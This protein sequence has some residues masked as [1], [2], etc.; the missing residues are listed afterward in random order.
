MTSRI[1]CHSAKLSCDIPRA[2]DMF[3]LNEH[4]Q[5]WL[6]EIADVEPRLGGKYELFWDPEDK[7][8][9]STIGCKVTAIEKH[10]FLAFEWKGPKQFNHFMNVASPLTHVVVFFLPC[11][12]SVAE[13]CTEVHLI[14]TGWGESAEWEEARLWFEKA[15]N[16][17]FDR[18]RECVGHQ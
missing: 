1:L 5:I 17:A 18:L 10:R 14:H 7:D 8:N 15:W 16:L 9:N 4:L 6:A 3:T 13:P 11:D 12:E 2:F